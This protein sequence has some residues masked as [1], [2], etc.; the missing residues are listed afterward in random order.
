MHILN[1]INYINMWA[2]A[3]QGMSRNVAIAPTPT[4][5]ATLTVPVIASAIRTTSQTSLKWHRTQCASLDDTVTSNTPLI[6]NRHS[7]LLFHIKQPMYTAQTAGVRSAASAV[8]D[9]RCRHQ[10][11]DRSVPPALLAR[12]SLITLSF[13]Y[14]FSFWQCSK[15][16]AH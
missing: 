16:N 6:L 13:I 7:Q 8:R 12:L 15:R 1:Y 9:A 14:C 4:H 3:Q 2:N 5:T 11:H 10:R